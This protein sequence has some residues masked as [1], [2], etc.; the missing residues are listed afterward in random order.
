MKNNSAIHRRIPLLAMIIFMFGGIAFGFAWNNLTAGLLVG[1]G[2]GLVLMVILRF[3]LY[4][5][6]HPSADAKEG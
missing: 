6:N 5:K 2:G 1:S 4:R 3:I